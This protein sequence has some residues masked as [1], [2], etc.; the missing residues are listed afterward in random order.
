M[1]ATEINLL[2]KVEKTTDPGD[3]NLTL[4]NNRQMAKVQMYR[5]GTFVVLCY[6][7]GHRYYFLFDFVS[8]YV[9]VLIRPLLLMKPLFRS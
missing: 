3:R 6:F 9:C 5:A 2:E 7:F 8:F 4:V 1:T